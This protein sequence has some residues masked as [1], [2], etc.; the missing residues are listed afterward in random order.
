MSFGKLL[1]GVRA[2]SRAGNKLSKKKS[3]SFDVSS[4]VGRG[5]SWGHDDK[6]G[7]NRGRYQ[8]E[9]PSALTPAR[10]FRRAVDCTSKSQGG[11]GGEEGTRVRAT[12]IAR[13]YM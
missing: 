4:W 3:D 12:N 9:H 8:Q 7:Y 13:A 2:R 5:G 11:V 10:Q 6:R 1:C